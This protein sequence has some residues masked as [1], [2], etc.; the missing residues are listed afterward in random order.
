[1]LWFRRNII[2]TLDSQPMYVVQSEAQTHWSGERR[3]LKDIPYFLPKDQGE[4]K[5]LNFEHYALRAAFQKSHFAP[6]EDPLTI[7]DV[8]CGT[9]LWAYEICNEFPR[10]R[11]V[12]FDL[13]IQESRGSPDQYFF[14]EGN[15]LNGIPLA[16]DSF[17]FVHQRMLLAAIPSISW[18]FVARELERVTRP[19]GWV[20]LVEMNFDVE[21]KGSTSHYFWDLVRLIA[22]SRGIIPDDINALDI[23]LR[24]AGFVA[25][26][27]KC[28]TVPVCQS[29]G[30]LG[31]LFAANMRTFAESL[32]D[33]FINIHHFTKE[34]FDKMLL[35]MMNEWE[36]Y[37]SYQT[38]NVVYGQRALK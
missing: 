4:V 2:A 37:R 35:E 25:V 30:R 12:G 29:G 26:E 28:F 22:S 32:R 21:P 33:P 10:A 16:N 6:V 19:G 1:M 24:Q 31:T 11:V 20:E 9:G 27:K 7:L 34:S 36:R 13:E 14:A 3:Y 8:G 23:H 17:D 18:P 5:R 15:L 38:I